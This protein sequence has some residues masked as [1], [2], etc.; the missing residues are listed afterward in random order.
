MQSQDTVTRYINKNKA[1]PNEPIALLCGGFGPVTCKQN[2]IMYNAVFI[3]PRP[4]F[5]FIAR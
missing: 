1:L 4:S 5:T 2:V 3:E